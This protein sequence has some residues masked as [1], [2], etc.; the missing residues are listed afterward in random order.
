MKY[1]V[2]LFI[3]I[4]ILISCGA[5]SE[6]KIT[7][8]DVLKMLNDMEESVKA[9]NV[10]QLMSH[11]SEDATMTLDMP[12]NMGG[13]LKADVQEYRS[14]LKQSWA[15]P[16]KFTYEVKDVFIEVD[17]DGLSATASDTTIETIEMNGQVI[18]SAKTEE[19]IEIISKD[20]KP[21]IVK[22]YGKFV[23]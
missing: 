21:V 8:S 22:L 17:A 15:L 7:E 13:K 14:M 20:G 4:F 5:N 2:S 19:Y 9:Q 10:D 3:A 16:A 11:F 1:I 12:E 6:R 23:H 18:A